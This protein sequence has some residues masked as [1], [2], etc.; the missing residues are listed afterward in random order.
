MQPR[1]FADSTSK[2]HSDNLSMPVSTSS[3]S[4]R[5]GRIEYGVLAGFAHA[6]CLMANHHHLLIETPKANLS[7]GMRQLNALSS[8]ADLLDRF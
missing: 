5:N 2:Q 6:Y 1:D 3:R 7:I 8:L 4:V